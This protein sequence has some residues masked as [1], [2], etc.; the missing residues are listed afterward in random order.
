MNCEIKN[1]TGQ[2]KPIYKTNTATHSNLRDALLSVQEGEAIQVT[3]EENIIGNI[4]VTFDAGTAEGAINTLIRDGYVEEITDKIGD[5]TMLTAQGYTSMQRKMNAE[6]T[7]RVLQTNSDPHGYIRK[8]ETF[9]ITPTYGKIQLGE[10]YYTEQELESGQD[11]DVPE[12]EMVYYRKLKLDK[13]NKAEGKKLTFTPTNDTDSSM[14]SLLTTFLSNIGVSLETIESYTQ[15][16]NTKNGVNPDAKAL[17]DFANQ[18][19]AFKD[20]NITLDELTEE[21]AHFIV[22]GWNQQEEIRNVLRNIDKT[23]EWI[24]HAEAYRKVYENMYSSPEQLEEA[25][26]R[27]VLGK[28]LAN[29]LKNPTQRT[30]T[31]NNIFDYVLNL[32]RNFFNRVSQ[33]TSQSDTQT[34]KN[35]TN[36]INVLL[37]NQELQDFL[38]SENIVNSKFSPMYKISESSPFYKLYSNS[39]EFIEKIEQ[40]YDTLKELTNTGEAFEQEV[41]RVRRTLENSTDS[42]ADAQIKISIAGIFGIFDTKARELK[43]I[44]NSTA[45]GEEISE[46]TRQVYRFLRDHMLPLLQQIDNA[47]GKSKTLVGQEQLKNLIDDSFNLYREVAGEMESRVFKN[48]E[49][50]YLNDIRERSGEEA[51]NRVQEKMKQEQTDHGWFAKMFG[52]LSYSKYPQ[53]GALAK[54]VVDMSNKARAS[55]ITKSQPVLAKLSKINTMLPKLAR[56]GYFWSHRNQEKIEK[57]RLEARARAVK[58]TLGIEESVEKLMETLWTEDTMNQYIEDNKLNIDPK[59]ALQRFYRLA[60]KYT[61][62]SSIV[63]KNSQRYQQRKRQQELFDKLNIS[64]DTYEIIRSQRIGTGRIRAKMGNLPPTHPTNKTLRKDLMEIKAARNN[65]KNPYDEMGNLYPGLSLVPSSEYS[66]FD[67]NMVRVNNSTVIRIDKNTANVD[68]TISFELN[69]YDRNSIERK[70]QAEQMIA[71]NPKA[72]TSSTGWVKQSNGVWKDNNSVYEQGDPSNLSNEINQVYNTERQR[73]LNTGLTQT[74]SEKQARETA[75]E[76]FRIIANVSYSQNYWDTLN[77]NRSLQDI[78][79]DN[80][81]AITPAIQIELNNISVARTQ[82]SYI[83]K[84]YQ[85]SYDYREISVEDMNVLDRQSV[86]DKQEYI[87]YSTNRIAELLQEQGVEINIESL[88]I[89]ERRPNDSFY[90]I[91]RDEKGKDYNDASFAERQQYMSKLLSDESN[92]SYTLFARAVDKYINGTQELND[93]WTEV[94]ENLDLD[95]VLDSSTKE[96]FLEAYMQRKLPIYFMRFSPEGYSDILDSI[97]NE[98]GTSNPTLNSILRNENPNFEVTMSQATQEQQGVRYAQSVE[99]FKEKRQQAEQETNPN[100]RLLKIYES[101]LHI[102]GEDDGTYDE[103]SIDQ[104]FLSNFGMTYKDGTLTAPTKNLTEFEALITLMDTRAQAL[105]NFEEIGKSSVFRYAKYPKSNVERFTTNFGAGAR[106][107][108]QD[109]VRYREDE[110]DSFVRSETRRIPKIG[111]K[112]LPQEDTASDLLTVAMMDLYNSE[113]Y[114]E[115]KV[116]LGRALAWRESIQNIK[117]K[118]KN[119]KESNV[120]DMTNNYI[121]SM[122]YGRQTSWK[123]TVDVLGKQ[124]DISKV[125]NVFKN[126]VQYNALG[127]S[128]P[129]ALTSLTTAGTNKFIQRFVNYHLY[130]PAS[131]RANLEFTKLMS[132]SVGDMGRIYAES[133]LERLMLYFGNYDITARTVN[134]GFGFGTR[135]ITNAS[136]IAFAVHQ[137]GNFPVIPRVMLSKLMEY[138]VVDGRIQSWSNFQTIQ[139]AKNPGIKKSELQRIFNQSEELSLYNYTDVENNQMFDM[140]KLESAGLKNLDGTLMNS[141]QLKDYIGRVYADVTADID[142]NISQYDGQLNES[143]KPEAS[144]HPILSFTLMFKSWLVIAAMRNLSPEFYNTQTGN[145]E[146]GILTTFSGSVNEILKSARSEG[147]QNATRRVYENLSPSQ[148]ANLK[149]MGFTF[150]AVL[151]FVLLVALLSKWEDEDEELSENYL[152]QLASFVTTRTM[153]ES[154]S[155]SGVGVFNELL[156]TIESPVSSS[157]TIKAAID[158]FDLTAVGEEVKRG[159]FEGMDKYTANLL[160]MSFLK[161]FYNLSSAEDIQTS[162]KGYNYFQETGSAIWSPVTL[163]KFIAESEQ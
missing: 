128:V 74:E 17:A 22:E 58:E 48:L 89:S 107:V 71:N 28:F 40:N 150:G 49:E 97:K 102:T 23:Q 101:F 85:E 9:Q 51:S 67:D 139:K 156:S 80:P 38:S 57:I 119:T 8:G 47:V 78:L 76:H 26:R 50:E 34:L 63:D 62:E 152:F 99:L 154:Y 144:R 14:L 24:E 108:L 124:I 88:D 138:R 27:E 121:D 39:S 36:R 35:F 68:A 42:N 130:T 6:E 92:Q 1:T 118:G 18:V 162:R 115:R 59:Q 90:N 86:V 155:S 117:I 134:A 15:K 157:N 143:L 79:D 81:S 72:N 60:D 3:L 136:K 158:I 31:E 45:K 159:N 69:K 126:F 151:S 61:F 73:L 135:N 93:I 12:P 161:N 66:P 96:Q 109:L 65:Y 129:V 20:G 56:G 87:K 140:K 132:G 110:E 33:L 25:V 21:T 100:Q 163:A 41:S 142:Y 147:L 4:P 10:N 106:Y 29:Q 84:K 149:T 2:E 145:W 104:S 105:E 30:E 91:F 141:N 44:V 53:L 77:S 7:Q 46:Q 113:V 83:L 55:F 123:G 43:R 125:L 19:I 82:M 153:V 52:V 70:E 94:V 5:N 95:L 37:R 120:W 133:K 131:N 137:I 16:Y 98:I 114:K 13:V 103:S 116:N 148:R 75:Y 112:T 127:F 64:D 146:Q 160:K 11:L 122:F 111:F 32:L 54:L